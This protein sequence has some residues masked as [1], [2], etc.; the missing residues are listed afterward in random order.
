MIILNQ[1]ICIPFKGDGSL[2]AVATD[3]IARAAKEVLS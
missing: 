3:S 1:N 2:H